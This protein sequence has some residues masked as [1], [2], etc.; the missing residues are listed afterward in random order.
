MR[1]I[2]A[3]IQ[4]EQDTHR[5]RRTGPVALRAGRARHREDRGRAAP[6]RLPAVRVPRSAG[7]LRRAGGRAERQLLVLHRRR[8]A[9]AGR[10]RRDPGDR[11]LPGLQ[12]ERGDHPRARPGTGGVDQGRRP[13]GRG[14]A[15]GGLGPSRRADRAPG[16]A[17]RRPPVAGRRLP[18]R[19]DDHRAARPAASATRPGR[20]MLPQ[21]LAHQVLLRMEAAGD[22]P[23]D[24][25]QNA[26]ARSKPVKAYADGALA[27]A[28]PG[29]VDL[30]AADRRRV[31]RPTPPTAS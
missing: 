22:S 30:A 23:D 12:G 17:P 14:A 16:G 24:R 13:D 31:P 7:P 25:V 18:R 19:R 21:R 10:D 8:A 29:E 3:T 1:D 20:A 11:R 27:G 4:P 2:V 9:R 28:G 26:V 6:R 15:P 5:P